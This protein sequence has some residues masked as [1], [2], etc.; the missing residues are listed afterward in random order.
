M[1]AGEIRKRITGLPWWHSIDLGQ[2]V[3]T[4][5]RW[6]PPARIIVEALNT[7]NFK[8]R[9]V[10]DVGCLDG[11]WSF[12]A[13]RRGAA[14]V[15]A[16]DLVS[17]QGAAAVPTLTTAREI[18]GSR[19]EYFPDV[20]VFDVPRRFPASTFDVVI[21]CGVYYHLKD[22][23]LALARLRQ[24]LKPGGIIVVEGAALGDEEGSYAT[25]H[26][27]DVLDNDESNWWVPTTRCLRE[28]VAC[29]FFEPLT[30]HRTSP[31]ERRQW[32]SRAR[33]PGRLRCA[34]TARAVERADPLYNCPDEELRSFDRNVYEWL[35]E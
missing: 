35:R 20:S 18:L 19:V 1:D 16:T 8:G 24:V 9:R 15:V 12:E 3:V 4:P 6:G 7:I 31:P 10:L 27:R 28:W 34:L 5:G 32:W 30:E 23:L 21:F 33:K 13:E 14:A 26:Y 17:Q 25:F 22:P 2:G 11:L 29:C